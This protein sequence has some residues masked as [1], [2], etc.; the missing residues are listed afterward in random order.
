MTFDSVPR[1]KSQRTS[2][3]NADESLPY[4]R[5]HGID[6]LGEAAFDL[7]TQGRFAEALPAGRASLEMSEKAGQWEFAAI[8]AI[9]LCLAELAVGDVA[10]AMATAER[11][12]ANADRRDD[13]FQI[14]VRAAA[15]AAALHAA[16]R[17]KEAAA[18]FAAA[19]R[20]QGEIQPDYPLLYSVGD[21]A[22]CDLLLGKGEWAAARDH[23]TQT[24][25]WANGQTWLPKLALDTLTLGRAH[26]GLALAA[27]KRSAPPAE[28]QRGARIARTR[29]DEAVEG[30]RAAGHITDIP[31]G[32]LARAAFWRSV[33]VW[34]GA[35]RDRDADEE[36]AEPGPM[37]LFLC[38]MAIERVRLA[39][40]KIE[41]FAPLN[42]LLETD[43]PPKPSPPSADEIAR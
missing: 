20:R 11:A 19:E 40:A 21:Y 17:R 16:G 22:Y 30:L 32:L 4:D 6:E 27:G 2:H 23:A 42:G 39:F 36:T 5:V 15:Q 8:A 10:S 12:V 1:I 41:A 28:F 29:L 43:N 37:K 7:R 24:H 34:G 14:N 35:T 25:E 26:L 3:H 33:G 9:S 13:A 18:L 31:R 38:D